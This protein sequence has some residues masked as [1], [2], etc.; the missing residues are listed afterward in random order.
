MV[1]LHPVANPTW[2]IRS[3]L[4]GRLRLQC[5]TL[6]RSEA[7]RRHCRTVLTGCHW[8]QGF[9]IN[10]VA[11]SLS[12][13]FPAQRRA[14]ID[15]LLELAL[16]VPQGFGTLPAL[17]RID[18]QRRR[19]LRHGAACAALLGVDW[20]VG[21]PLLAFQAGTALLMLP[22][23]LE[24]LRRLRHTRRLPV[25]ALDLG[26]SAV[27]LQQGLPREALT[28]LAFDD[29]SELLQSLNHSEL[30]ATDYRSLLKRLA[31]QMQVR[32]VSPEGATRA[33]G[34]VQAGD[35]ISLVSRDPVMLRCRLEQGSLVAINRQLTGDWHPRA[36]RPGDELEPGCLVVAGEAE[37]EVL[38]AFSD[39]P[40]FQLPPARLQ[41][42]RE[43]RSGI[44]LEA[45]LQNSKRL[46]NPV[47]FGL[48]SFWALTGAS[49]RALAAFQFNPINDWQTSQDANRLAAVTELRLHGIN[50]AN[51]EVMR[52][53]GQ[54]QRLLVSRSCAERLKPVQLREELAEDS[55]L[56]HGELVR[57]L[58]GLQGWLVE[59]GTVPIWNTQLENVVDPIAVEHFELHDLDE[60]GW[61]LRLSDGR[62]LQIV[63]D[64]R[65][66]RGAQS[67]G[68]AVE[69]LEFR[70]GDRCLGWVLL[71]RHEN[72][73]WLSVRDDLQQLGISVEVVGQPVADPGDA[74][75][76]LERVEHYQN[77]GELV[78]YLGDV[79]HDIPALERADVA[80]G[81]DFDE[82]GLLTQRL[83]DVS[84][85]RDPLWLPRL[86][87]LSRRLHSTAQ[88]NAA[89]IGLT[90]LVSSV[91]TA[92]LAIS[93]LQTVLL[94]DVPLLLA[95][96]RNLNSF[97][98]H[99][100]QTPISSP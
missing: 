25:E 85:N 93:P 40:L 51:P 50:I 39:D 9:R 84:L 65:H 23:V 8:L 72:H 10:A 49:E 80:I 35:R 79:I 1:E 68:V 87:V 56:A 36:Y 98:S 24:L 5:S 63:R 45:T 38:Q 32:G 67:R 55:T 76:R 30:G 62:R 61:Q 92:G 99:R 37:L 96:L 29:G 47:L 88:S 91:A 26:F 44:G 18:E 19:S 34:S 53:V 59:D 46:I 95:E 77:Q 69:P 27:L 7:L 6:E 75:Q 4:P 12:L 20:L 21:L 31:E 100:D 14:A 60:E 71:E 78:G 64:S 66:Q 42:S 28:D 74:W 73:A 81:L 11:G 58:A 22:L 90:H 15:A 86:I 3:E 2:L 94:A 97:Q 54:L 89:M 13:R 82:A 17:T 48:G 16:K 43:R 83:C 41:R 57:I 33:L 70:Q 52:D